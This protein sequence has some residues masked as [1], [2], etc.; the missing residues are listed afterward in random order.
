MRS[1]FAG[2]CVALCGTLFAGSVLAAPA[3]AERRAIAAYESGPYATH[4]KDIQA[5]AGFAVPVEVKWETIAK[6]GEANSY[7]AD[8]YWTNIFFVPL[9]K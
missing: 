8:A 5:A 4:L 9:K 7:S 6:P 3:L 1:L 2:L